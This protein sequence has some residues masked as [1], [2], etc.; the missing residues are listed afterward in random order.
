MYRAVV[1]I[2]WFFSDWRNSRAFCY[3]R[4][5]DKSVQRLWVR[6]FKTVD[7]QQRA[8][9]D[10][11]RARLFCR[12]RPVRKETCE[13]KTCLVIGGLF[14]LMLPLNKCL[15]RSGWQQEVLCVQSSKSDLALNW[16]RQR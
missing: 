13:Q 2:E 11:W 7:A 15:R 5:D 14:S 9:S 6:F 4:Q 16:L 3:L 1:L 8:L 12:G 10:E